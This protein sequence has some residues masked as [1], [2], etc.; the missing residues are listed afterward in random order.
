MKMLAGCIFSFYLATCALCFAQIDIYQ[1]DAYSVEEMCA[2]Q[3]EQNT[4]MDYANAYQLCI[5]ENHN[6]PMYKAE[7]RDSDIQSSEQ[8]LSDNEGRIDI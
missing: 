8:S 6:K 7:Q 4:E 2:R 5:S 3:A 1:S